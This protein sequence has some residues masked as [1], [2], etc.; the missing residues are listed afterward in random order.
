MNRNLFELQEVDNHLLS[1]KRE[2]SKLDDG[3][4]ARGERDTL[5]RAFDEERTRL[6]A[7]TSERNDKEL[8]LKSAEEKIARQQ[9][10]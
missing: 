2:R 7:L 3:T 4:H 6:S 9:S 1:L 8:Q 5:Q 10:R